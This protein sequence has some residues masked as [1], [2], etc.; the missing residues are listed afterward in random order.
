[1]SQARFLLAASLAL[2]LPLAALADTADIER[3]FKLRKAEAQAN[4]LTTTGAAYDRTL[5]DFISALPKINDR[6]LACMASTPPP[7]EA[8]GYFEFAMD[9]S[10]EL[11]LRPEGPFAMCLQSLL[12]GHPLPAPPRLPYLNDFNFGDDEEMPKM[13]IEEEPK[14]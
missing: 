11:V 12:E 10:Y 2:A 14:N 6:F 1:M 13:E 8:R 3:E 5:S 7:N 4:A 9:G